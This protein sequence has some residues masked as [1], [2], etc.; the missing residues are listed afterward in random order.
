MIQPVLRARLPKIEEQVADALTKL[1][2]K[3]LRDAG[4]PR[5]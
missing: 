2:D 3:A 5:G 4:V 1:I